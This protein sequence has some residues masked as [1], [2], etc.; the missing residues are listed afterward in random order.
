MPATKL[1]APGLWL[2]FN[3]VAADF[4]ASSAADISRL[5][6]EAKPGDVLVLADGAW[7]D[8]AILF[9]AKGTAVE[10]DAGIGTSRRPLTSADVGLAWRNRT[11]VR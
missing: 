9:G 6:A 5:A 1:I 2:A 4:R 3:V 7:T 11:D 10:L 8:Q